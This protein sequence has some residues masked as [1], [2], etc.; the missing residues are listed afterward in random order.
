[1]EGSSGSKVT[2]AGE[3]IGVGAGVGLGVGK[4]WVVGIGVG[5]GVGS[6]VGIGVGSEVGVGG[7]GGVGTIVQSLVLRCAAILTSIQGVLVEIQ[8]FNLLTAAEKPGRPEYVSLW[9]G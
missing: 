5:S 2:T 1:M 8:V 3:G 4:G 7:G 9:F 6:G